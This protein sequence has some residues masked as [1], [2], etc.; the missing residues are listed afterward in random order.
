M[1]VDNDNTQNFHSF[2]IFRLQRLSLSEW[3]LIYNRYKTAKKREGFSFAR[4]NYNFQWKAI[5]TPGT[6]G[7]VV[8]R[9]AYRFLLKSANS[10]SRTVYSKLENFNHL[11]TCG[12]EE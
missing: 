7:W 6:D 8:G 2:K 5:S 9:N 12:S 1:N 3:K 11:E 10:F 4:Q